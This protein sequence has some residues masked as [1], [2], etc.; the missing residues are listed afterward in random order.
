MSCLSLGPNQQ[1]T[2]G[3]CVNKP[4]LQRTND[5]AVLFFDLV[6]KFVEISKRTLRTSLRDRRCGRLRF[7][8][9]D[10]YSLLDGRVDLDSKYFRSPES[11]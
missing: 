11:V 4:A 3:A 9:H 2:R 1:F 10:A 6:R 8:S 7:W 5:I